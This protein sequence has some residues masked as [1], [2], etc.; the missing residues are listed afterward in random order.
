MRPTVRLFGP[1]LR[2]L[3][4]VSASI[5]VA[6][7]AAASAAPQ[8][9]AKDPGQ[10][11]RASK[12]A[13]YSGVEIEEASQTLG[14]GNHM[15]R[16]T[17][18]KVYRDSAGRT[19]R[20]V[21]QDDVEPLRVGQI[22]ISDPN[23]G[24]NYNLN[25]NDHTARKQV[26]EKENGGQQYLDVKPQLSRRPP[27][28]VAATK[29]VV[30]SESLGEKTIEGYQAIGSRTTV[31]HPTGAFGFERPIVEVWDTWTSTELHTTLL[32]IRDDPRTG[33]DVVRLTD[34]STQDPPA[35]LFE[36]PPDYI[37]TEETIT[38]THPGPPPKSNE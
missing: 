20:E 6:V 32:N 37:L 2:P 36:V 10:E 25:P 31:T 29:P 34:I 17:K 21:I 38:R 7:L 35:S 23:S 30:K 5:V 33:K 13:P 4:V 28:S 14:D 9:V 3:F 22:S 11:A 8:Q 19:R 27:A 16:T 24:V 26:V 12:T 18:W 15:S 1:I